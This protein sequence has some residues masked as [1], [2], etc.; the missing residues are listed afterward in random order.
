MYDYLNPV[1]P[2]ITSPARHAYYE[3]AYRFQVI[4]P[5][6]V[7]GCPGGA[8]AGSV[9]D[10]ATQQ[11]DLATQVFAVQP[12]LPGGPGGLGGAALAWRRGDT[13]HQLL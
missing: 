6:R 11:L 5:E 2:A 3:N 10:F 8:Q 13:V 9:V 1:I 7:C 4:G 12:T